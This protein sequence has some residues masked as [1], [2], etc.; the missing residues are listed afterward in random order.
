VLSV[1]TGAGGLDLG[2]ELAGFQ[3]VAGIEVDETARA[4]V[5]ANRPTWRFLDPAE[6]ARLAGLLTPQS[7][8]MNP[9]DLDVLAG[10]PPCQPFSK[11]AQWSLRGAAGLRDPRAR[12]V[13]AFLRLL[14]VFLPR[15]MLIENVPGFAKG[16]N[17]AI[18]RIEE[19]LAR[20]NRRFNVHYSL[21]SRI[22]NAMHYGVPQR[23]ERAI[24][25]A[26]R[27]RRSFQWPDSTHTARPIRAWDALA[28]LREKEHPQL[29][30]RWS[31]LLPSIPEGQN[32]IW[33][34]PRGGGLPLFGYRTRYWSFLLKLAKDQPAWT[35]AAQP[36]PATGPFHWDNRPLTIREM[37]RLQSFPA[38]WTVAGD[39]RV[40]VL[41][42]GN[43]T[44]P[45]LAEVIGRAIGQQIFGLRYEGPPSLSI[46]RK[47]KIPPQT[48]AQRV[49]VPYIR[50]QGDHSPHPGVG[51][52]P[53]PASRPEAA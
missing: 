27:D 50:L 36:G 53:R 15:V 13:E 10:G 26:I 23:R 21:Q 8:G 14:E 22:L 37:L 33:H 45:L 16:R 18:P 7:I 43:A 51:R 52:G 1:F 2:L 28:D 24:L 42:V 44:P 47:T 31:A 49:P 25:V 29:T 34:T 20:I 6:V 11:A 35:I 12:C 48:R 32:Y 5:R 40:Q 9:G 41:Q 39:R 30:G 4:T 38:S 19:A 46:S 3:T 17:N